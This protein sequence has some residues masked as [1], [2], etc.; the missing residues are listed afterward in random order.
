MDRLEE[1][2]R[3][4]SRVYGGGLGRK[5]RV[6]ISVFGPARLVS[7]LTRM[8]WRVMAWSLREEERSLA[9]VLGLLSWVI[10]RV[11]FQGLRDRLLGL[12]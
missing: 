2:H 1:C 8:I 4:S 6:G 3:L 10:L 12:R 5:G 9:L 11:G 7:V